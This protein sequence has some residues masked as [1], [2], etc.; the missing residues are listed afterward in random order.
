MAD[1]AEETVAASM[2]V[3]SEL[4]NYSLADEDK[5]RRVVESFDLTPA[6][7]PEGAEKMAPHVLAPIVDAL[8]ALAPTSLVLQRGLACIEHFDIPLPVSNPR[9][10]EC[11]LDRNRASNGLALG[12]MAWA[13]EFVGKW[14]THTAQLYRLTKHAELKATATMVHFTRT[15]HPH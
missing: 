10:L 12:Q 11:F 7:A 14:L 13:G 2:A 3:Q 15:T 6:P 4:E 1:E 8:F 5:T 9:M